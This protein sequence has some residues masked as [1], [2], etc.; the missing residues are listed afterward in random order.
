[1]FLGDFLLQENKYTTQVKLSYKIWFYSSL[2][3][4]FL[5]L[6][7]KKRKEKEREDLKNKSWG[8]PLSKKIKVLKRVA[9]Q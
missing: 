9:K 4:K 7:M 8:K 6:Q 3:R 1:M 5:H 2:V